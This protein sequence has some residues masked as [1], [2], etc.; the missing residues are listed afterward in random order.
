[1]RSCLLRTLIAQCSSGRSEATESRGVR[2]AGPSTCMRCLAL[3]LILLALG[4]GSKQKFDTAEVSGTVLFKGKPLPGGEVTFAKVDGIAINAVIDED[5]HY[6]I[7]APIGD[8]RIKVDNRMLEKQRGAPKSTPILKRPDAEAPTPM[9]GQYV[10]IPDKYRAVETSGLTYKVE[11]GTQTHD[12][13][14]E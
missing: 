10:E 4:C 14:L 3:L 6:T 9:K 5:G 12:I 7:S 2:W 1:M 13:T 8:V 11:K